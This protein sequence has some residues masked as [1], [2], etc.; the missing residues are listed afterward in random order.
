MRRHRFPGPGI[1]RRREETGMG[2]APK[3]AT[4]VLPQAPGSAQA[5]RVHAACVVQQRR[6]AGL[7]AALLDL[8][9]EDHMVA[10]FMAMAVAALED[11]GGFGQQRHALGRTAPG[12]VGEAVHAR[13]EEHTSELQSLAY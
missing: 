2:E 10:F 11:G 1:T 7:V 6:V 5:A 13:S 8:A 12:G 4:G 9:D 3:E